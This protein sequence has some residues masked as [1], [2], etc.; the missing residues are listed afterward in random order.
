MFDRDRWDEIWM[1]ISRNK[2]RSVLTMFGVSWGIFMLM[3]MLGAGKGLQGGVQQGFDG[4]ATNSMFLWTQNTSMPYK[5]F[6]RGRRFLFN[7]S[8]I[9]AIRT[10]IPD[11]DVV[12]PRLQ[13]GGWQG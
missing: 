13:L 6:Q 8:D 2:L 10:N 1:V 12:A 5:G 4:W 3:V 7:N 9:E 11:A